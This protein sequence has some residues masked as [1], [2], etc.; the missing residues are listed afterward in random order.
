MTLE[1][2]KHVSLW[3]HFQLIFIFN[4]SIDYFQLLI[5]ITRSNA[6]IF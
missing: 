6:F 3:N 4:F 1:S 2:V 5:L